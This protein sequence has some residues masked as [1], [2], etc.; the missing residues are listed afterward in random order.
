MDPRQLNC[1]QKWNTST[2]R[3]APR[4]RPRKTGQAGATAGM[5]LFLQR[6]ASS[7]AAPVPDVRVDRLGHAHSLDAATRIRMERQIG[8]DLRDVRVHTDSS[9]AATASSLNAQAFTVGRD[10]VFS[11]GA[12]APETTSGTRLLAHELTHVLQQRAG[13]TTRAAGDGQG[14][15]SAATDPFEQAANQTAERVVAESDRGPEGS[16]ASFADHERTTAA[17]PAIQ[18]QPAPGV[19]DVTLVPPPFLA[20]SMGSQTL[21]GF[22]LD[23]A[24]LT[25]EQQ[26]RLAE[27]AR[28]ILTL[29]RS[30][31]GGSIAMIGHT[32]ATGTEAHNLG[33]GARRAAAVKGALVAAGVPAEIISTSSAGETQPIVPSEQPEPRNRRVEV[34]FEP[35]VKVHLVPP[36]GLGVPSLQTP[37]GEATPPPAAAPGGAPGVSP[38]PSLRLPPSYFEPHQETPKEAGRRFLAPI[39]PGPGPGPSLGQAVLARVDG[40]LDSAMRSLGIR[41]RRIQGIV[42]DAVHAGVSKAASGALEAALDQT[43]LS[44]REKAAIQAAVEA[45]VNTPTR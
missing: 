25:S 9:A 42:R 1:S 4:E 22:G 23:S 32:D 24:A 14:S 3:P 35:E 45:A 41:D 2:D 27:L 21:D 33:L 5:P 20:R 37:P 28:A 11:A 36:L 39:P 30:Y 8:E 40:A 15:I 16:A 31:P 13:S 7:S 10:V 6:A 38:P 34:R 44:G 18:R 19:P 17:P 12:Y 43:Q 29:L 26:E